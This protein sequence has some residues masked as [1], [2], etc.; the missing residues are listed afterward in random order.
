M[1]L[2][3][4]TLSVDGVPVLRLAGRLN[5]TAARLLEPVLAGAEVPVVWDVAELGYVASAGLRVLLT[6]EQRRRKAG[7]PATVLVGLQPAV[8]EVFAITGLAALWR[9]APSLADAVTAV[10]GVA[11]PQ[12]AER[13]EL[14]PGR[15]VA[16]SAA[17]GASGEL[18]QWQDAG[19][20]AA[21][22][23]DLRLSLGRGGLGV[24]RE[25]A[26]AREAD[27]VFLGG[28]LGLAFADG[29]TDALVVADPARQYLRLAQAC[30]FT[31]EP[32]LAL[33]L[34]AGFTVGE[35][36]A[37][38]AAH[39]GKAWQGLFMVAPDAPQGAAASLAL[40]GPA[41]LALP[42]VLTLPLPGLEVAAL[43]A[44]LD[45]VLT[46]L[47]GHAG[48]ALV[49]ADD[50]LLPPGTRV[51]V[52]SAATL[53]EA[54]AHTLAVDIPAGGAAYH[55]ETE[56]I[57]RSLYADCRQVKLVPLTGGFSATTWQIESFDAQGRRLLPTVLKVG[58]PAMMDRE[59]D[60]HERYVGPFVLNNA[61]IGLGRAVHGEA[62]GLR[63]NFVGVTGDASNL[64]TLQ[65]RWIEGDGDIVKT[66]HRTLAGQT[67]R[68]WYGQARTEPRALYVDHTPLRLFPM[69]PEVARGVLG[70]LI[71]AP[72]LPCPALG[73][74]LPNPWRF[75]AEVYPRRASL[76]IDCKVG[77]THGDM[78][79]NN[80]LADERDNL[81]VID[82]SETRERSVG[83]DFARL[84]PV[85]LI[86]RTDFDAGTDEA[87]WLRGMEQL[88]ASAQPWHEVPAALPGIS[89]YHRDFV[90]QLREL[91]A[92]Y[93]G[94]DAAEE[95][96]LL[97][98]LEWTLPIIL[99][100]NRP[101][102][103][104]RASTWVA[105]LI[106]ERLQRCGVSRA[107]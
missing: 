45:A 70:D 67:L 99:F 95:A 16:V 28:L 32:G 93:L 64:R 12:A 30:S 56:L 47:Q 80:V 6:H 61:S 65:R 29:E 57:V 75:L 35:L 59:H 41:G 103:L 100:G 50:A 27:F 51:W 69:L 73:R 54:G 1:D 24:R 97:P 8:A 14:L 68:P 63:Y 58:P 88:Y 4:T 2:D 53:Q 87:E 96:Y 81:Y 101:L 42:G 84:E 107:A 82:F 90:A 39:T 9:Q 92:G 72:T 37:A 26:A 89:A 43:P 76:G 94:H 5:N 105:A 13:L 25:V 23:G 10:G 38:L 91:A 18:L 66:L 17:A 86:E 46:Q 3:V 78:N 22:L 11:A 106:V 52:W 36:A 34:Q 40:A 44:P 55:D 7:A 62:V 21:S 102:P 85:F 15:W 98:L 74:D 83:S 33:T 19:W 49:R 31:G 60:A 20:A 104:R 77:I 48:D 79:L 71:D